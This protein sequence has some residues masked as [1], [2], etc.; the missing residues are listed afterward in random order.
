VKQYLEGD[1]KSKPCMANCLTHCRYKTDKETFCIAQ[2]LIDSF[3]GNWE[4]GLFFC[5]SNVVK[6]KEMQHVEDIMRDFFPEME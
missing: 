2:S 5:G 6:V 1:V 3:R 4:E